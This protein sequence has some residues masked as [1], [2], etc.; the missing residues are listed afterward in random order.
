[1]TRGKSLIFS[2]EKLINSL[3]PVL[4]LLLFLLVFFL[5][6]C[7]AGENADIFFSAIASLPP[8]TRPSVG[9]ALSG[10]GARGFAHVGVLEALKSSAF[11]VDYVSGTSMGS[12]VGAFYADGLEQEKIWEFGE[13]IE[14][15]KVGRDF[16]SVKI[17]KLIISQRFID[18]FYIRKFIDEQF[19]SRNFSD[20]KIPFACVA[21][22]I[23]TGEKIIF[24]EGEL[25]LALKASVNLP[26][27]FEPISYGS[28]ELVDG[29][30]VDFLPADALKE[31]GADWIISSV[32]E[33]KINSSPK[34]AVAALMQ[35]IDIRGSLLAMQSKKESDFLFAPEVSDISVSDFNRANEA[36]F[37]GLIY[38]WPRIEELKEAYLVFSLPR[39]ISLSSGRRER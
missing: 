3:F 6:F 35:V 24:R 16:G 36:A 29:G 7:R 37:K 17:L 14:K 15:Y 38:S 27:I 25:P 26:G 32:T 33:S 10:G 2:Q 39:T 22:D 4:F 5:G 13:K 23:K 28:K 31:M 20:L 19:A 18:P 1:M 9:L 30:V 11:P 12:V 34:N 21:M 8:K